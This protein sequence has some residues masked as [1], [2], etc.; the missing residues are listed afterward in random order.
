MRRLAAL[1][2]AF[3]L[4]FACA[5]GFAVSESGNAPQPGR[6]LDIS[7][8][9]APAELVE[10]GEVTLSFTVTN[11]S[12]YDAENVYI[13]SAD[14]LS[15]EPLGQIDAGDSRVFSRVHEVTEEELE[16]GRISYTFSHDGVAGDANTVNYAVDCPIQRAIA[17]PGVEFTRQF[18]GAYARPGDVATIVYR[19]RNTGNVPIADLRVD[20][21][22]GEYSGRAD[23][24][25]VGQSRLF[26]SKV[27]IEETTVSAPRLRYTVPAEENREYEERL[28]EARILLADEQLTATLTLDRETARVGETVVATLTV[29]SLGNV[30]FYDVSVFD[31]SFGGLIADG[32]TMRAGTQTLTFTREYPVREDAVYQMRVRALSPSG[33]TVEVLSEPVSLRALP[34]RDEAQIALYAEPVYAQI[35]SA[36]DAPIDVYIVNNGSSHARNATLRA[37]DGSVLREFALVAGAYTTY[38]RVYVPVSQDGELAFSL[39]YTDAA[40]REHAVQSEPVRIEIDPAGQALDRAEEAAPYSGESV[41]LRENSSFWFLIAGAGAV[42]IA[43]TVALLITSRKQRRQRREKLAQQRRQRQEELGK[44]NRFVP[45]KRAPKKTDKEKDGSL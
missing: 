27:T 30:D 21:A 22:P 34:V 39:T 6:I 45:V 14:G 15:T 35:A 44:T 7:F 5:G 1:L 38:R 28:D 26:F 17:Q 12:Q 10:P 33:A 23:V 13:S 4:A 40:G 3:A 36:G 43:L 8:S 42:L 25:E 18:T 32:L 9:A 29:M 37:P 2:T 31:E 11:S 20:D 16:N 41:K 19:V 24:L